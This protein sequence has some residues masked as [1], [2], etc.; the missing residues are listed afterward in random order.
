[1]ARAKASARHAAEPNA[2]P[3]LLL[4]RQTTR[5]NR[6]VR[7]CS[8]VRSKVSGTPNVLASLRHAPPPVMFSTVQKMTGERRGT[9]IF[10]LR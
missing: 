5:H 4:V 3:S 1:V 7:P 6:R 8:N 9:M 10:A 2:T